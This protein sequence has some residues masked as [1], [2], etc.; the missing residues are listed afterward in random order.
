MTPA[1]PE[2]TPETEGYWTALQEGRLV[3]RRCSACARL[4]STPRR[5]C[6]VCGSEEG[7]WEALPDEAVL[8]SFSTL[9]RPPPDRPYLPA[10][11]TIAIV[12]FGNGHRM[13]ALIA[14]DRPDDLA[15]GQAMRFDPWRGDGVVLP[16]FRPAAEAGAVHSYILEQT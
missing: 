11:C 3:A 6:L 5:F 2:A 10:P 12:E 1:I 4:H 8:Y 7:R 13:M 15:I 16:A 9:G 14:T